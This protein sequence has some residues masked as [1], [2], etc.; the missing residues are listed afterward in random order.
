MD[1][2]ATI[3]DYAHPDGGQPLGSLFVVHPRPDGVTLT[4]PLPPSRLAATAIAALGLVTLAVSAGSVAAIATHADRG[5]HWPESA[6]IAVLVGLLLLIGGLC[7]RYARRMWHPR[8]LVVTLTGRRLTVVDGLWT[9]TGGPWR[10]ARA[11]AFSTTVALP[12]IVQGQLVACVRVHRLFAFD[13]Q[14]LLRLPWAECVWVA[15]VLNA[16]LPGDGQP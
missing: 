3:L 7:L 4:R 5:R 6:T 11:R 2:P 10:V 1:R 9:L 15:G 16:A 12:D 14:F 8:T 13:R